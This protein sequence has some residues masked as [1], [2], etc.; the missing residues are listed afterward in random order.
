MNYNVLINVGLYE[1]M[2]RHLEGMVGMIFEKCVF[3][4]PRSL[5]RNRD[6][7]N[8]TSVYPNRVW[9]CLFVPYQPN[10]NGKKIV[11]PGPPFVCYKPSEYALPSVDTNQVCCYLLEPNENVKN[12]ALGT[13]IYLLQIE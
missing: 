2:L 11:L 6:N 10:G 8:H 9:S 1:S 7:V 3:L 4:G 13:S 12:S 5:L